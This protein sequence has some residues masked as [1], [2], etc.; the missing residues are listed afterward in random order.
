MANYSSEAE[1]SGANFGGVDIG[2]QINYNGLQLLLNQRRPET[3]NLRGC[4]AF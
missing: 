3:A 2:Q 1:F 4:R